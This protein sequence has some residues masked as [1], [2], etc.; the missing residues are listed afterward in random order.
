MKVHSLGYLVV[1]ST[2]IPAW[3]TFGTEILGLMAG[4]RD[5]ESELWLRAD[6]RCHRIVVEAGDT[7]EVSAI[8]WELRNDVAF[9]NLLADL[10]E[11]DVAY[12]RV[13]E[14]AARRGVEDLVRV[15]DPA[16]YV[17]EFYWG[18]QVAQS[19]FASP[20][21]VS[22][23]KTGDQGLGHVV[24]AAAPFEDSNRFYRRTLGF[25]LTDF[26]DMGGTPGHFLHTNAR[27]H[28]L[29]LIGCDK[30]AWFVKGGL[31]HLM[32]EM[33]SIPD[34]GLALTRATEAGC[35][36]FETLGQ[37]AN[38]RMFSFY[39]HSPAGFP[40]EIGAGAIEVDP[41]TWT[42]VNIPF[43]DLWGHEVL[44]LPEQ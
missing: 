4:V 7:D 11:A 10:D 9:E 30:S 43:P 6:E 28:S 44:G 29:A 23:F 1:S 37:H 41:E 26:A 15:V 42:S 3:R 18:M 38:D 35:E 25:G 19:D 40:I 13:D 39:L 14:L 33:K 31:I 2:D 24:L 17:L 36:F 27:H 5:D 21:G 32:V 22:G 12:E 20:A 8:G 34:V 16:G